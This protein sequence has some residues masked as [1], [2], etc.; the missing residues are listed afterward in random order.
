MLVCPRCE[1][2]VVV[3][4]RVRATDARLFVCKECEAT[5][6]AREAIG[7]TPWQDF[8]TYLRAQGASPVWTEVEIA[9]DQ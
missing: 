4:V 1:Q 7:T 9:D 6:L 3:A 5:W 8:G 2:G